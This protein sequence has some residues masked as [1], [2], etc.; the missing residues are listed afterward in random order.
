MTSPYARYLG[1][2]SRMLRNYRFRWRIHIE[3]YCRAWRYALNALSTEDAQRVLIDC[4][5]R[6]GRYPLLTL[7]VDD[8]LEQALEVLVDHPD[9]RRLIVDGCEHVS[10]KWQSYGDELYAARSRAIELATQYAIDEDITFLRRDDA[11]V[12]LSNGD[13]P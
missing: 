5:Y 3:R 6:A 13:T 4:E 9:L 2:L 10:R 1:A 11:D 7:T 8:T 12:F